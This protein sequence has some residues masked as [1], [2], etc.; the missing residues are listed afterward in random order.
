M[1]HPNPNNAFKQTRPDLN[2]ISKMADCQKERMND[3]KKFV[4][5]RLY[6]YLYRL[7]LGIRVGVKIKLGF[8]ALL[9]R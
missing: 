1:K 3:K 5:F 7:G 9:V 4:F 8:G 2:K 6:M